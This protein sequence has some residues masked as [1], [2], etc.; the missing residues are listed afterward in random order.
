RNRALFGGWSVMATNPEAIGTGSFIAEPYSQHPA[1]LAA[2]IATIDELSGGRAALGLGAG[3]GS[4][5]TIGLKRRRPLGV[6]TEATEIC[7][8][9]LDGERFDYAGEHFS[10]RDAKLE[11]QVNSHI[12]VVVASRG[13]KMLE[14]S[15]RV[16]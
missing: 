12:P 10:L 9:L 7:R 3:G 1:Q 15:G 11:F 4:L 14:A 16:A 8:R 6:M 13:D 2:G 5:V